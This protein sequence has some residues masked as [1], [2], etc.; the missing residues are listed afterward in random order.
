MGKLKPGL[1]KYLQAKQEAKLDKAYEEY[2]N[3]YY[4]ISKQLR[5]GK[6]KVQSGWKQGIYKPGTV[7]SFSRIG[8][9]SLAEFQLDYPDYE[10]AGIVNSASE[11]ADMAFNLLD[12]T[13]AKRLQTELL[14]ENLGYY[15]IEQIQARQLPQDV[16]DKMKDIAA[17]NGTD[18][19]TYFFGS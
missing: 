7:A 8:L 2:V 17:V 16:W 11:F 4:A 9:K 13:T 19:S 6:V 15:T 3:R 14:V 12:Y 5:L 18:V 10:Y 1:A